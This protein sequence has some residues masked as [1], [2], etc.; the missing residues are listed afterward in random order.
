MISATAIATH[1]YAGFFVAV[2]AAWL[3]AVT[4]RRSGSARDRPIA[5]L[6]LA[7]VPVVLHQAGGGEYSAFGSLDSRVGELGENLFDPGYPGLAVVAAVVCV[8]A[9]LLAARMET[10]GDRPPYTPARHSPPS[11]WWSQSCSRSPASI[12]SSRGICSR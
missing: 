6:S 9:L 5:A 11:S 8:L 7:Y 12:S 2:E 4:A 1:Y 10:P 3:L